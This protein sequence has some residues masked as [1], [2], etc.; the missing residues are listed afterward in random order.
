MKRISLTIL[1][2]F[3]IAPAFA[4]VPANPIGINPPGLKWEQIETDKVQV[5]FPAGLDS[6]GQ[7]VA[8][9]VHY[10][11]DRHN[12]SIG[13]KMIPVTI[14]LQNQTV[15]SNGFVT[16]GPFRSEFYTMAPQFNYTTSWLDVLAIHEYRHVKQFGNSVQGVTKTVKNV[17]GSWPWG[18]MWGLALPRWYFEGD[19]TGMETALTRSGRGRLPA[20]DMEYRS[21]ILEDIDY[22]YEKAGARSLKDFV[23][24]WYKLGY[25]MTIHA[26]RHYGEDIWA[27]VLE[28]AVRYRGLFYPFS[29]GLEQRTGLSTPDLYRAT[30]DE[31]DSLWTTRLREKIEAP[32]SGELV[33]QQEKKTVIHYNHP[34]Y[35]DDGRILVQK[36]GYN[37]IPAFYAVDKEGDEERFTASGI[38]FD[39]LESSLSLSRGW[40]CWA[41]L[42]FDTRWRNETYSVIKAYNLST[43]E[44]RKL[45]SRSQY[46]S[47]A[48]SND[49]E[50]IVTVEA[51]ENMHYQ[52]VILD[53]RTG[54]LIRRLPNYDSYFYS[55]PRW[56]AGDEQIVVVVNK[57]EQAQLRLVDI[58]TGESEALTPMTLRQLSHPFPQGD[59]VFFSGDYT[60][61]SNIFALRRRDG[62]VFQLTDVLTGAFQPSV[63]R[64]G[65]RLVYSEFT[66]QGYDVRE[67]DLENIEW[68][69][70]QPASADFGM[71]YFET[72]VDQ[73]GGHI[74]DKVPNQ[75]F[76]VKKF[77]K[78]SGI[79]NP[80]SILPYIGHPFYG[81]QLLS[82]NKFSTMSASAN[83]FYNVNENEVTFIGNLSYAELFPVINGSFR[84]AYRSGTF[85]N[86]A[87]TNDTT[88]V[89]TLFAERWRENAV[90]AGFNIPL[91]FSAGNAFTNL[92]LRADYHYVNVRTEDRISDVNN[93]RDTI[94]GVDVGRLED[95]FVPPIQNSNLN[96][97]DL[98]FNFRSLR[99]T[100]LQHLNP[101]LGI[102]LGLRYRTT[103]SSDVLQG[104]SL[105]ARADL[106]LPGLSRNHSFYINAMYQEQELLD[107]YRFSDVFVYPR[108]YNSQLGDKFYKLG[109][110]YSLPLA[111]PDWALGPVAFLKRIKAN[112]FFDIGRVEWEFP[113][114]V[115]R[116]INST[117]VELRFDFRAFRLLEI[118]AGVRYSYLLNENLAPNGNPHQFDFLVISI[119]E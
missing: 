8:N 74:T 33:N 26:R 71:Q 57:N 82:D 3:G 87:P 51:T 60:G 35:L 80:H 55:F 18:G 59:Y 2:L 69:P 6:A 85:I 5:I 16:P 65:N 97:V 79:I 67:L 91:N 81:L 83:G 108:G 17:L 75:A 49:G 90:S 19:A 15:I 119:S 20:F 10:L 73:E 64:D 27:G 14:L 47:P 48:L 63:S 114:D 61:I 37:L 34:H 38:I 36:R 4:Q 112:A 56:L 44:K 39:P 109:F 50:R 100:A 111:Y 76:P 23:P 53:A 96:A 70:F 94:S 22:G 46:F 1:L 68:Q 102:N 115:Q 117:G 78:W 98:S 58:N 12:E 118:D 95:I 45:S 77:N 52:L 93:P 24:T 7:R 32:I 113:F 25:Y 103:F 29:K 62:Q 104:N 28:D 99:R 116:N 72:L 107:N 105:L 31:L 42:G 92:N 30:Y 13:E 40:I 11:W 21:L 54:D 101:R 84:H 88:I 89:Q 9:I 43:G 106:F 110:N 86:F 41:E 66:A